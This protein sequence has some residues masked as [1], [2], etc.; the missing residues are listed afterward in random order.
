M[1]TREDWKLSYKGKKA[2]FI[3]KGTLKEMDLMKKDKE[4]NINYF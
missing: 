2:S 1:D 4:R 3:I